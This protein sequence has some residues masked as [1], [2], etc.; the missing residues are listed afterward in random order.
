MQSLITHPH[1]DALGDEIESLLPGKIERVKMRFDAFEDGWPNFFIEDAKGKIE[2]REVTYVGD[3]S[4]PESLFANY[5]AI[6]GILDYYAEKVR[7]IV[8]YFPVGTMERISKKGEIATASYFADILSHL[9]PGR[10]AKTSLH[11][12]DIHALSERF[13]F[14]SFKVN[15]ELHSA[16][17]LLD[18]PEGAAVVFPDDGAAKRFGESFGDREKIVCIKVREGDN[19][20][21]TIKEGDPE[22]KDV[23]IVDDLIRTG[24][25]IR[26]AADL[27]RKRGA[28]SVTAFAPHGVFPEGS[29]AKLAEHLDSLIVTDTLPE[30]RE[31]A[32]DVANLR[33]VSIAP[34]VAKIIERAEG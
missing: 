19:R 28:K 18:I 6:R 25:T 4:R 31:R 33:V 23:F 32:R 24:G 14:D 5:A 20:F 15:M 11:T 13:F 34:L 3:F 26:E 16:M 7:V 29:H 2:H 8:P 21:I 9:P 30:N 17:K 1:F 22:G 12:F 27:L 10:S